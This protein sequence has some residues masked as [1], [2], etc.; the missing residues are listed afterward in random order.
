[1]LAHRAQRPQPGQS[2]RQSVPHSPAARASAAGPSTWDPSASAAPLGA[3]AAR[4]IHPDHI[5]LLYRSLMFDPSQRPS[6]A[7]ILNHPSM[8]RDDDSD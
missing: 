5:D 4:G 2:R 6:A 3:L 1:M 7:D 8:R